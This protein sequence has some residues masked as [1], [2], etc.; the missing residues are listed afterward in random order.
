[1]EN[2]F[3]VKGIKTADYSKVFVHVFLNYA[4]CLWY[5]KFIDD[6]KNQCVFTFPYLEYPILEII[7]LTT[8]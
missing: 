8:I 3:K 1:M 7:T 2:N 4:E 5:T 6:I